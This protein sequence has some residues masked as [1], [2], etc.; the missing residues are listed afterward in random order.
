[1][2]KTML[3]LLILFVFFIFFDNY[4]ELKFTDCKHFFEIFI[5]TIELFCGKMYSVYLF[6]QL[7]L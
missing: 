6:R 1:M 5:F 7:S 3:K 2:L 4:V